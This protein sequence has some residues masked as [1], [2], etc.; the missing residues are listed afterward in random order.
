MQSKMSPEL[1]SSKPG[2]HEDLPLNY[3]HKTSIMKIKLHLWQVIRG[4]VN[5]CMSVAEHFCSKMFFFICVGKNMAMTGEMKKCGEEALK[6]EIRDGKDPEMKVVMELDVDEEELIEPAVE[7]ESSMID[8]DEEEDDEVR[9]SEWESDEETD[10]EEEDD[11]D[12]EEE[13]CEPQDVDSEWSD[14]DDEGD[15]EA[16][17]ESLELWESFFNS[18]DPYNPLSFCSSTGSRTNTKQNQ[19]TQIKNQPTPATRPEECHPKPNSKEGGKK[20]NISWKSVLFIG[21]TYF[22]LADCQVFH[23]IFILYFS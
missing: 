5:C 11:E 14:D 12:T 18:S 21:F 1:S 15:S 17:A 8:S 9:L 16:S 10:D 20:V 23:G 19:L 6:R 7:R 2:T 3:Y 4:V 13:D 22:I